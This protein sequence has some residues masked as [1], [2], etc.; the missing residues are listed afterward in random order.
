MMK[1]RLIELLNVAVGDSNLMDSE[2]KII[3]DYLLSNGVIVPP[4]KVGTKVFLSRSLMNDV[5]EG[6][7]TSIKKTEFSEGYTVVFLIDDNR[8][9]DVP[10]SAYGKTVFLTKKEAEQAL[11]GGEG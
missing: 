3:A 10:F 5:I 8:Y 4:C 9:S 11:K 2:V 6:E 7:V 1:A